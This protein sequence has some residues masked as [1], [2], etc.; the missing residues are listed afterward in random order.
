MEVG[1]DT[2]SIHTL[3]LRLGP[4]RPIYFTSRNGKEESGVNRGHD[5]GCSVRLQDKVIRIEE[6]VIKGIIDGGGSIGEGE[7]EE[8]SSMIRRRGEVKGAIEGLTDG[9][10]RCSWRRK[11]DGC[12]W[13][14]ISNQQ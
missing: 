5:N 10:R 11:H 6:G 14:Q 13:F 2:K 7:K 8:G 1:G 4:P 9:E 3:L 12:R